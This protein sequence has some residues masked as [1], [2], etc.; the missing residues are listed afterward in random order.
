VLAREAPEMIPWAWGLNGAASVLGSVAALSI[1]LA[2]G[3]DHA[4]RVAAA[5]YALALVLILRV[6]PGAR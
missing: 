4:L 2:A 6:A 1:A 3:F 5:L